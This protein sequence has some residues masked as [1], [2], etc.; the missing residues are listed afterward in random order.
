MSERPGR[1][2]ARLATDAHER[3]VDWLDGH[4]TVAPP[5]EVH[6]IEGGRSHL[7]YRV[8]DSRGRQWVLRRPPLNSVLD[9]AHDVGREYGILAAMQG[10]GV[11]VPSLIGHESTGAVLGAPFFVMEF[12]DGLVLRG[13][14]DAPETMGPDARRKAAW[15]L[16]DTLVDLHS[17]D[18]DAVGL[19]ELGR[20]TDYVARQ[21]RRWSRQYE[22]GGGRD[23]PLVTV[24]HERLRA[25]IP[26]PSDVPALVHG[27]YR[28]DN[29]V[30]GDDGSIRAVLDWEL[31]TLGEPLADLGLLCAYWSR[32]EG[33]RL[34]MPFAGDVPGLPA[35]EAI[36]QR[37]A[38]RSSVEPTH[39]DYYLTLGY[40]KLAVI[41]DGVF[42]R[43]SSG[44][45][46]HVEDT[47]DLAD[48]APRL[49]EVGMQAAVRAGI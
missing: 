34:A 11:P 5:V 13:P 39:L 8:R 47:A 14:A 15:G 40:W 17:L 44:A 32:P 27:D 49:L 4:T 3:F 45:Y 48:L 43:A 6:K 29:I 1:Q 26:T 19:G 35:V 7:T 12:V 23:L 2:E 21:L 9:S 42:S 24:L 10:S 22:A 38:E 20:R 46:G 16:V 31:C 25:S 36:V 37:Y 41:A 18:V 28:L 33:P 30:V